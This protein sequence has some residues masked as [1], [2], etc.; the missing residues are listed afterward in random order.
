MNSSRGEEAQG[1]RGG[2]PQL[3][4]I[5]QIPAL[6]AAAGLKRVGPSRIRQLAKDDPEWPE[7]VFEEGRTR[8]FDWTAVERYFRSRTLRQGERTDLKPTAREDVERKSTSG[9]K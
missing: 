3:V 2:G 7:P 9:R 5:P 8:I 4:T 1:W 6:L